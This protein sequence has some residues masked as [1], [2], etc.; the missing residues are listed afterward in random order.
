MAR[1]VDDVTAADDDEGSP[2]DGAAADVPPGEEPPT[3][4]D[5]VDPPRRGRTALII[6]LV[7]ALV[8]SGFVGVLATRGPAGG[9]EQRIDYSVL[10][11]EAFDVSGSTLDGG[12][13]DM[14]AYGDRWLVVNF[15]ATWCVPCRQE[16][17]ELVEFDESHSQIGDAAVV[18]VL[19]D[20]DPDT[21]SEYF[22]TNG[23]SWPVV[24][25][26]DGEVSVRYGVTG[27]PE[28]Y[29][30][31]PN[32]RLLVRITGGVTRRLIEQVIAN[33]EAQNA[34]AQGQAD[35]EQQP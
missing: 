15:F 26:N 10:G 21:A 5:L 25:D 7:V 20:D 27:V 18:S 19:Y 30:V 9:E 2:D 11:D 17:P 12:N 34:D 35:Q 1:P 13:F 3:D 16:H 32:G 24:L 6:S 4:D 29:L 8:V 31:A 28:T 22:E 23:G 33:A 14:G